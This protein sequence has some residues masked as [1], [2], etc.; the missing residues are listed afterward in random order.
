M[1]EENWDVVML[2]LRMQTQW[3]VSMSG[4]TGLRYEVLLSPGGLFDLYCVED[5]RATLEN[6]QVMESAALSTFAKSR[7]TQ[8]G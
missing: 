3:N 8:D 6:L 1:W 7:D 2:F 5:R 4:Y